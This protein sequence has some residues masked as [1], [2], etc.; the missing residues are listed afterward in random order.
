[1]LRKH[2]HSTFPLSLQILT[3]SRSTENRHSC[4]LRGPQM[5]ILLC[6]V[7][8]SNLSERT[9]SL[10]F[11]DTWMQQCGASKPAGCS[12]Q[13]QLKEQGQL[14]WDSLS[15]NSFRSLGTRKMSRIVNQLKDSEQSDKIEPSQSQCVICLD[16]PRTV[17]FVHGERWVVFF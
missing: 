15:G 16:K 8:C 10:S 3:D 1:M 12:A 17:G 7:S 11:R 4:L 5:V 13:G 6:S 9:I 14:L 2:P